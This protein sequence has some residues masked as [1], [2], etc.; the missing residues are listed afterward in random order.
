VTEET[1]IDR[2]YGLPPEEFVRARDLAAR[3]FRACGQRAEAARLKELRRPTTAAAAVNR[4][5]RE[6]RPDVE[7][8]LAAADALQKAQLAGHDVE[9]ATQ[10]ERQALDTLVRI[11]GDHVR[12]SMQAAAVDSDAA[13]YFSE[14]ASNAS[15]NRVDSE[16]CSL[17]HPGSSVDRGEGRHSLRAR[18][19]TI[20]CA[21]GWTSQDE[22]WRTP[23]L[24][25][26]KPSRRG[27]GHG[28]TFGKQSK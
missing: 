14:L 11:G 16:P 7:R 6:H 3:E 27:S 1:V 25:N 13:G 10:R 18:N 8:F 9:K 17:T 12:Q 19:P 26:A 2:L 20:R 21:N 5:V 15:S 4:V 28:Q 24:E 22:H 23:R